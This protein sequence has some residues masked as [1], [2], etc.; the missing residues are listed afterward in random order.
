MYLLS[1]LTEDKEVTAATLARPV[2]SCLAASVQRVFQPTGSVQFRWSVRVV[3]G[4]RRVR[5]GRAGGVTRGLMCAQTLQYLQQNAKE[6]AE[7]VA[8]AAAGGGGSFGAPAA[9]SKMSLQ[10]LE[11][12]RK[13]LGSVAAGSAVQ[14]VLS[15]A[16]GGAGRTWTGPCARAGSLGG[17]LT[18][19][20]SRS[21]LQV[22]V[23]VPPVQTTVPR[24]PR[25]FLT[26]HPFKA[27]PCSF[28]RPRFLPRAHSCRLRLTSRPALDA[29]PSA[30]GVAPAASAR[31]AVSP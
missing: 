3:L 24:F 15:S 6:R 4:V 16:W 9:A 19:R 17:A 21:P 20:G 29:G 30:R 25:W 14:Q 31:T 27:V 8:A 12:L 1:K 18:V 5:G 7:L 22:V 11:E 23:G 26:I 2:R 10:E 28:S 13:Q